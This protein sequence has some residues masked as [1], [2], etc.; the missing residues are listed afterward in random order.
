MCAI[1]GFNFRDEALLERMLR[2]TIHRGPDGTRKFFD[3]HDVSFGFN[4]L[5]I[6]DLSERAM[7]PMTDHTGRYTLVFNGEIYNFKELKN[8]LQE[9]PF[10]TE[11]DAEVILAAYMRWGE[12]A[13]S[14][15]NGMFALALWDRHERRLTLA[16]DPAGIKPLY[17]ALE[18]T[19]LIFSSEIKAILEADVPRTLNREAFGHYLRLMYVPAPETLFAHVKK[20]L[21]GHTLVFQNGSYMVEPFRGAWPAYTPPESYQDAVGAVR[22]TVEQSIVRQLV[23]DRPIGV[24]LSGGID[25]S[26]IASAAAKRHEKL[27]TY[28]VGFDLAENE[29]QKKFNADQELARQTA[30][31]LG[32][33]HHEFFFSVRDARTYI[34]EAVYHLDEPIGNATALAQL[35]L[36]KQVKPTATVVLA[37]DGGDELFGG[38]ERYRLAYLASQYGHYVPRQLQHFLHLPSLTLG[39]EERYRQLMFQKESVIEKVCRGVSPLAATEAVFTRFFS[40]DGDVRRALMRTDEAT[41][42]VEEALMR[43]D[44]MGM[45][46]S[47]EVRVPLLDLDV[48]AYAHGLPPEYL[49]NAFV[50]KRVLRDAF[51]KD[52]PPQ[53]F[54]AP[55]RGWFSP[56]AK[57]LRHTEFE[58]L[59]QEVLQTAHKDGL[60]EL[61]DFAGIRKLWDEHREKR[62]YH[63][64][65]LWALL[66]FLLW[67]KHYRITL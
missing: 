27:N 62:A 28:A 14:K 5:A 34:E 41:W 7:Q 37:G 4:R 25:S 6:I 31:H 29:E 20:L 9:Y 43:S 57:W 48:R 15:L 36:A 46:G 52:L 19:K 13:F 23:S 18:G 63:Y 54:R 65:I 40:G 47:V 64:T 35:F 66:V 55:K 30:K 44:K 56:G 17:Y 38:Y 10:Q 53:V 16:R 1:N 24:Y 50:T 22:K 32:A 51:K 49:V 67:A 11:G 33:V 42:L 12:A 2:A 59:F 8:E 45:A 60:G 58:D 26:V 21:P 3:G 39:A 61:L